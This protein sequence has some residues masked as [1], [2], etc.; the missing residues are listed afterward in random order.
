MLKLKYVG[1]DKDL[2]VDQYLNVD[3]IL[4]VCEAYFVWR[5]TVLGVECTEQIWLLTQ[6]F[7]KAQ[8]PVYFQ[9]QTIC[10][11]KNMEFTAVCA[12]VLSCFIMN[13]CS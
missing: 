13:F 9:V 3:R 10:K 11:R 7:C 5:S 2:I 1:S 8:E 4:H 12:L 6:Q